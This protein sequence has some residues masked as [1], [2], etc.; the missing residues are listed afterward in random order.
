MVPVQRR[1][2]GTVRCGIIAN[3]R[4]PPWNWS[5]CARRCEGRSCDSEG[6]C[7]KNVSDRLE[8]VHFRRR[9]LWLLV[10]LITLLPLCS[11]EGHAQQ[12]TFDKESYYRA[13]EYCRGNV[14]RPMVLSN[15]QR[16]LCFDG[17]VARD[18]DVSLA[19]DLKQD[20]LFVV[21][22]LG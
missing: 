2:H 7:E 16:V 22:S 11:R 21:R 20:G 15:D 10:V 6:Y 3:I 1:C 5:P 13:L 9:A 18:M 12:E 19:K 8:P 14:P 4:C 17:W